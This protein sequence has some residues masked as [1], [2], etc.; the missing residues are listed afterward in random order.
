M[1]PGIIITTLFVL[2]MSLTALLLVAEHQ[3]GIR[4]RSIVSGVTSLEVILGHAI[5]Q[6]AMAYMQTVLMLVVFVSLFD[7]PVRGSY[8]AAFFLPVFM[9]LCGMCFGFLTSA[10][11]K[12][13]ATALLLSMACMYPSLLMG[14]V[15]W[16]LQGA[17][18]V[19]RPLS[20]AMPQAFPAHALRGVMLRN[21]T[22]DNPFVLQAFASST[23][24]T[25]IYILTALMAFFK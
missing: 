1:S 22:L 12:D 13:E 23:L 6:M 10:V 14:G 2:S 9:A 17:P 18:H 24:W 16:P 3:E 25:M 8:T 5:V 15:L 21:Y 7:T 20:M 19:L 4:A 11:S